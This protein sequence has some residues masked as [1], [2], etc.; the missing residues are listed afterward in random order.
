MPDCENNIGGGKIPDRFTAVK[1]EYCLHHPLLRSKKDRA[2]R[3][4]G[5]ID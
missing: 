4:R 3:E 1:L 2:A 5:R